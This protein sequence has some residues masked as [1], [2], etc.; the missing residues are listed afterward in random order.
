[1]RMRIRKYTIVVLGRH[2]P[3]PILERKPDQDPTLK[4]WITILNRI[5]IIG[6][7]QTFSGSD[8]NT[9]MWVH[10]SAGHH[11]TR[12]GAIR[13]FFNILMLLRPAS[14]RLRC[15][16]CI[17]NTFQ[18]FC[19]KSNASVNISVLKE[20]R[21]LSSSQFSSVDIFLNENYMQYIYNL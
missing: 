18:N 9:Q 8:Q 17:Y 21:I 6:F 20:H 19:G 4:N 15:E 11:F 1:M 16:I 7:L 10:S 12:H 5:W 13:C 14:C 2:W 3:N